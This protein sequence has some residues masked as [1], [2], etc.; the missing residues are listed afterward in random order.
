MNLKKGDKVIVISGNDKG[1]EGKIIKALP[2]EGEVV[3]EG[4][5]VHKKHVRSK[6][7][8]ESGEMV[9][10]ARPIHH[11]NISLIC[12]SCGE[13]TRVGYRSEGGDKVR[14]CKKCESST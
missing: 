5:N 12:S 14:F 9:D 2:D 1:K 7:K 4:V 6:K 8:G 13:P 11:S 10:V 3:V